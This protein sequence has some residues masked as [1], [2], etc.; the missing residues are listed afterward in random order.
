MVN[1]RPEHRGYV[2]FLLCGPIVKSMYV[3]VGYIYIVKGATNFTSGQGTVL[4]YLRTIKCIT[5]GLQN[6]LDKSF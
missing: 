3:A 6:S 5:A 1:W 2:P 4:V